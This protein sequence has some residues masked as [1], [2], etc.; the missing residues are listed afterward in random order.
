M[1]LKD[2]FKWPTF[3][4]LGT[5]VFQPPPHNALEREQSLQT[6]ILKIQ[7]VTF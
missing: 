4:L 5:F 6:M 3:P 2:I 1:H 7:I